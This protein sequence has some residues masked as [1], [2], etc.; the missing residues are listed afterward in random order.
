LPL[1]WAHTLF[2]IALV[3]FIGLI[4]LLLPLRSGNQRAFPASPLFLLEW[5]RSPF[6]HPLSLVSPSRPHGIDGERQ[7]CSLPSESEAEGGPPETTYLH[8]EWIP[9]RAMRALEGFLSRIDPASPF[10]LAGRL[11]ITRSLSPAHQPFS[12]LGAEKGLRF[13]AFLLSRL[14]KDKL[15]PC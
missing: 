11:T 15:R 13:T 12:L 7:S 10:S 4:S 8:I 5:E 2:C 6:I 14:F 9:F 3:S 1:K